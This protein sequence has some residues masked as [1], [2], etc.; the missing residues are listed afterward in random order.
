MFYKQLQIHHNMTHAKTEVH[1]HAPRPSL[2]V[3]R[4]I[5]E[6]HMD[7]GFEIEF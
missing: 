2:T 5:G 4:C 6:E 7:E 1:M 3:F